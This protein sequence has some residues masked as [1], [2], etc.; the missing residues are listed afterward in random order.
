MIK[1]L[2][3]PVVLAMFAVACSGKPQDAPATKVP[4]LTPCTRTLAAGKVYPRAVD[5]SL[6]FSVEAAAFAFLDERTLAVLFYEM[7]VSERLDGAPR[8][9]DDR[10]GLALYNLGHTYQTSYVAETHAGVTPDYMPA[11][12]YP[13]EATQMVQRAH[14]RTL[15]FAGPVGLSSFDVATGCLR[16]LALAPRQNPDE[17]GPF[18]LVAFDRVHGRFFAITENELVRVDENLQVAIAV[19]APRDDI[20]R[21]AYDESS[22]RL[23]RGL[24]P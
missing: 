1:P 21:I 18:G 17:V 5:E 13:I 12:V 19:P 4:P 11:A 6:P 23:I 24:V 20:R 9:P 22:D 2:R 8:G 3:L 15:M 7:N 16:T 14:S 10:L